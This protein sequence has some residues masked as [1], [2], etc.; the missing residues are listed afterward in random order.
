ME[1]QSFTYDVLPPGRFIRLLK[2]HSG[3]P[4]EKLVCQTFA[5]D[6]DMAPAYTAL[7]YVWGNLPNS[8]ELVCS[9]HACKITPSLAD[10]LGRIRKPDEPQ[11]AW[12]DAICINQNDQ[13]EKGHQ[14]DLMGVI[15][16]K[17]RDVLVWL[18]PDQTD[19]SKEAFRC[20]R[21]INEKILTQ[22][23]K[24][25]YDPPEEELP[26]YPIAVGASGSDVMQ[27]MSPP[28]ARR[29]V[30]GFVLGDRG[31]ACVGELFDL[32]WFSR[33]WVLQEVGLATTA[34]VFW[35][36]NSIDFGEIA[37][38]IFNVHYHEE[39]Q[40]FLGPEA[41]SA[42]A[43]S[44]LYALWNIWATYD[45]KDSWMYRTPVLRAF[46][47]QIAAHA[48]IDFTLVLE[49]SRYFSATNKLDHIYAF[50]GHPRAKKPG[51]S[52]TWLQANYSLSLKDQH[53][54]LASSMAQDSL[55]FLVQAQ[56]TEDSLNAAVY[57]S[58]VPKWDEKDPMHS[59]AFW[60]AWD[61]SLRKAKRKPFRAQADGDK[62]A[63]LGLIIDTVDNF[64]P[65]MKKLAPEEIFSAG[66]PLVERCWEVVKQK[67]CPYPP[68]R[69][70][71]AFASTLL[72]HYKV[73]VDGYNE[74]PSVVEQFAGFCMR[75]DV[76]F[77]KDLQSNNGGLWTLATTLVASKIFATTFQG[78]ATN[79]RFFNTTAQGFWGLGPGAMRQGDVCA[80]L[81]GADVP[82][83]LR[84]TETKGQ[85]KVVGECYMYNFM[86]GDVVVAW[87][88]G[89][90][91]Y[92][93][94][95]IVLV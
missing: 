41:S 63:I 88:E 83:V 24:E 46:A 94:E 22:T 7:S 14:V 52:E 85:Y 2:I 78:Y 27:E 56:Q 73:R 49:A 48:D 16:D 6:L 64:T 58:W 80:V 81:L 79:R 33:V 54:L 66:G 37:T 91:P 95:D 18:G 3:S 89:K 30:L 1:S 77:F 45:K 17:A 87:Q 65:T 93:M 55:N 29:S 75:A 51:T 62:L 47:E 50:L 43:G 25:W 28:S 12:A 26:A 15:Y 23:D 4:G 61:A 31:K 8:V 71:E 38:F 34:T 44:P 36:D 84:P 39:L 90:T 11:I 42:L 10:G 68:D 74:T 76:N 59:Q 9:G 60:E 69:A 72:C 20:L 86:D 40:R 5:C 32:T 19:S 53:R 82:F 13:D 70:V 21:T 35:G 67:P 92:T 57:P